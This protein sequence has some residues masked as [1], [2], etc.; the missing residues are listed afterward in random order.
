[1]PVVMQNAHVTFSSTGAIEE[2]S[3]CRKPSVSSERN[4]NALVFLALFIVCSM[5]IA[6]IS[7]NVGSNSEIE[8][9]I[10]HKN[11]THEHK[12]MSMAKLMA[13]SCG[14]IL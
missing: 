3:S 2:F 13:L 11:P 12:M 6:C 10:K 7:V 9:A 14:Q 1:M 8:H 5:S 4:L